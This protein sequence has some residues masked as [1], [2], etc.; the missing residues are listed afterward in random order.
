M[1]SARAQ[2]YPNVNLMAFVGLS[3]LGLDRLVNAGSEQYGVGPAL[4]LPI[5]DAGRLRANLRGKASEVDAAVESYNAAVLE[6]LR[7][8]ADQ[9]AS[10]RSL[11]RQ[12]AEQA[13]S[14]A[15]A[16]SAYDL[17]RQ[18]YRAGLGGYLTVL[19]AESAVLAQRRLGTDLQ[20]RA[21]DSQTALVRAL[22]G[23]YAAPAP[24]ALRSAG[25]AP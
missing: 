20:A 2:F 17:A 12:Q 10:L 18:R 25:L 3:S 9:A 5:F 11:E 14:Q 8:V 15:S 7:E 13:Q 22:G 6:A 19:N 1:A 16:E 24:G 21:L 23:G 4:R